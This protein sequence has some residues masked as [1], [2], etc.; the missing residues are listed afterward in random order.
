MT[1]TT[2]DKLSLSPN[3]KLESM[4]SKSDSQTVAIT[5]PPGV[6]SSVAPPSLRL[7]H[8]YLCFPISRASYNLYEAQ[9]SFDIPK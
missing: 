3:A 6:P 8:L 9:E 7:C 2:P 5:S 4:F 1:V